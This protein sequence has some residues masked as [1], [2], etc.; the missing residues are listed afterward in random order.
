MDRLVLLGN[1][2]TLGQEHELHVF[3]SLCHHTHT[4]KKKTLRLDGLKFT[5]Q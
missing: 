1:P 5:T 4:Q 3:T 2:G